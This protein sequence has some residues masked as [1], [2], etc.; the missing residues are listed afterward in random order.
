M[1]G[2]REREER[3]WLPP[4]VSLRSPTSPKA[5][6][7]RS[8]CARTGGGGDPCLRVLIRP[9]TDGPARTVRSR[10]SIPP[11]ERAPAL[12]STSIWRGH[13]GCA[14][15]SSHAA[16]DAALTRCL[17]L[18]VYDVYEYPGSSPFDMQHERAGAGALPADGSLAGNGAHARTSG[19]ALHEVDDRVG[20]GARG[21]HD[22][23]PG[24]G[25]ELALRRIEALGE[26]RRLLGHAVGEAPHVQRRKLQ[27][28]RK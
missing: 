1:G 26:P 17:P 16:G 14:R 11:P 23:A 19:V 6:A 24:P 3:A 12:P 9:R 21:G 13:A 10:Q 5:R 15:L 25:D 4:P 7:R 22:V 20:G 2:G 8:A 18:F 27:R 28:G